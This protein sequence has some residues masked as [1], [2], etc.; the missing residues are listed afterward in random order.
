MDEIVRILHGVSSFI[1]GINIALVVGYLNQLDFWGYLI[2]GFVTAVTMFG[3]LTLVTAVTN[4]VTD[5]N[6]EFELQVLDAEAEKLG[7][8]VDDVQKAK[9]KIYDYLIDNPACST[10]DIFENVELPS[11]F[12]EREE[13]VEAFRLGGLIGIYRYGQE[14]ETGEWYKM[15]AS[16]VVKKQYHRF[17][18]HIR[19]RSYK[20]VPQLSF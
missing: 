2:V 8:A 7:F 16:P 3:L 15:H 5:K 18:K 13:A 14:P 11:A 19:S 20:K 4:Y 12:T 10:S 6:N 1:T 17:Q 9:Y